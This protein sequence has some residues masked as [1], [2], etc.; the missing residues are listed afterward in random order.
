MK[1]FYWTEDAGKVACLEMETLKKW[2]KALLILAS[3]SSDTPLEAVWNYYAYL[4]RHNH[5]YGNLI[6]QAYKR[7]GFASQLAKQYLL[8]LCNEDSALL[9]KKRRDLIIQL[10]QQ[11]I[12]KRLENG[13]NA[14]SPEVISD[15]HYHI[16]KK[17][18]QQKFE[19]QVIQQKFEVHWQESLL[20]RS[21]ELVFGLMGYMGSQKVFAQANLVH[22]VASLL[23]DKVSRQTILNMKGFFAVLFLKNLL[24]ELD[25]INL[26]IGEQNSLSEAAHH[27]I[28]DEW[29]RCFNLI[30]NAAISGK[31]I[32]EA[33]T[34][35]LTAESI[36][37]DAW[38]EQSSHTDA[39]YELR[40]QCYRIVVGVNL[41][42]NIIANA[43]QPFNLLD[44]TKAS[45]LAYYEI[46]QISPDMQKFIE[47]LCRLAEPNEVQD[48]SSA[49]STP[50][51]EDFEVDDEKRIE[52]S[53]VISVILDENDNGSICNTPFADVEYVTSPPPYSFF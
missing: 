1:E 16:L 19:E 32:L 20:W 52:E 29:K 21:P 6:L 9:K 39:F 3:T 35:Q 31:N 37:L 51:Q 28:Q 42:K 8:L 25:G 12:D 38:Q 26:S 14:I 50:I 23:K 40:E 7:R 24:E 45:Y 33:I 53:S 48:N 11:D 17:V 18:I 34:A 2:K 13:G 10:T 15:Y 27:W 30:D 41:F 44:E 36:T 49:A 43:S 22:R 5:F 47:Y 4:E 46:Q